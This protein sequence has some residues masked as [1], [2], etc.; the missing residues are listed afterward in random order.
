MTTNQQLPQLLAQ[1]QRIAEPLDTAARN[2]WYLLVAICFTVQ[3]KL[4]LLVD[5][6]AFLLS[7]AQDHSA[8]VDLLASVREAI[9]TTGVLYGNPLMINALL[10]LRNSV[11][12]HLLS[13]T[14]LR[15]PTVPVT[16]LHH[17]GYTYFQSIYGDETDQTLRLLA[18]VHP[19]YPYSALALIFGPIF[20]FHG[21]LTQT[22]TSYC[23]CAAL[24]ANNLPVQSLWH[25][26][27]ALRLG[28]S[29]EQVLAVRQVVILA[30]G[31]DESDVPLPPA[32]SP[33]LA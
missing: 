18:S 30:S 24:I 19:D 8:K 16:E 32:R 11:D 17:R 5:L 26:K 27:G 22:E 4:D 25:M 28:A 23:I 12:P 20:H 6:V 33:D 10:H 1:L 2:P 13:D 15:D 31:V 7:R 3:R 21:I 29:R 9:F 14:P